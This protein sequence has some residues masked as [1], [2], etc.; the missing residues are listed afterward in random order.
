MGFSSNKVL[1]TG[2]K[3]NAHIQDWIRSAEDFTAWQVYN[4]EQVI[5]KAIVQLKRAIEIISQFQ[6]RMLDES[7]VRKLFLLS[8]VEDEMTAL[9]GFAAEFMQL[10][11]VEIEEHIGVEDSCVENLDSYGVALEA[12][13]KE[14]FGS[15]PVRCSYWAWFSRGILQIHWPDIY[16]DHHDM[17]VA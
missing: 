13:H 8:A 17:F 5:T 12:I 14:S 3:T 1:E 7:V 16:K 2:R 9:P 10:L 6:R 15:T 4:N 11:S